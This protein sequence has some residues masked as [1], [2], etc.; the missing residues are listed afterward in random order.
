M[1]HG[2]ELLFSISVYN[3]SHSCVIILRLFF[4]F[5]FKTI[6]FRRPIDILKEPLK[7]YWELLSHKDLQA[8]SH[9][10]ILVQGI[11]L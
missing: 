10:Q 1:K 7:D 5:K 9:F 3:F 2:L 6:F 4:A 8:G 11:D